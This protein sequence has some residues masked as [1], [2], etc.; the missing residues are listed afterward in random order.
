MPVPVG[1]EPSLSLYLSDK[2]DRL[3]LLE[4]PQSPQLA[5]ATASA[6][7]TTANAKTY[8]NCFVIV[9]DLKTMAYSSGAH[10]IRT[11]TGA[12]II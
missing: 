1:T 7:L 2:E 3:G 9:T 10:W 11:D 8:I 5:Y 6:N 12:T 4:N